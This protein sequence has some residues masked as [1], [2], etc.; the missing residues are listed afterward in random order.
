MTEEDAHRTVV[1]GRIAGTYG[2]RGWVR[3]RS[4]TRP[5]ENILDYGR[6]LLGCG[7]RWTERALC[8]GRSHGR[9]LV[10][11][12]EGV[13]DRD[14]ALALVGAEI[15]VP[16]EELPPAEPGEYYWTD[17][18][19]L[20][21]E[22]VDGVVLGRVEKLLETGAHDVLVIRGERERLIPFAPG[23]TV[24]SVDLDRGLIRV[25]WDPED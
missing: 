7:G 17:L 11:L 12:L 23:Q 18:Q 1:L 21:V 13:A 19:G 4:E 16:Y 3:V 6:W 5:P 20:R 25:D 22:T 2:V 15:A 24:E 9:G 10:A 8:E 14:A